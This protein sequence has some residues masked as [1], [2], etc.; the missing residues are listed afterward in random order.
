MSQAKRRST[1]ST[2]VPRRRRP[3]AP[4]NMKSPDRQPLWDTLCC[5]SSPYR[6]SDRYCPRGGPHVFRVAHGDVV[7]LK[8]GPEDIVIFSGVADAG[9]DSPTP[10]S[11]DI[12]AA[13]TKDAAM[14]GRLRLT[15]DPIVV[16]VQPGP[17]SRI[18][19]RDVITTVLRSDFAV[20]IRRRCC[21]SQGAHPENCCS[22]D[23]RNQNCSQ[24]ALAG[25]R[26]DSKRVL[27]SERPSTTAPTPGPSR[28]RRRSASRA[29]H[30]DHRHAFVHLGQ[31]VRILYRGLSRHTHH[32]THSAY[33][34]DPPVPDEQALQ[35]RCQPEFGD[36]VGPA[37]HRRDEPQGLA[38]RVQPD[39]G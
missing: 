27:A 11:P 17:I 3:S 1:G 24:R 18:V 30:G 29:I 23:D 33:L 39:H 5:P 22:H 38:G 13:T 37:V 21:V 25:T 2:L 19:R 8:D 32:E 10:S 28:P 7:L 34:G 9:A 35:A 20:P 14:R 15:A 16:A 12:T 31:E 36:A 26:D 6:P 4:E